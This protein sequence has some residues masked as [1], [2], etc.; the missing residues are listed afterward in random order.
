MLMKK[1]FTIAEI[2]MVIVI[3]GILAALTY[4]NFTIPKEKALDRE[5]K[6]TLALMRAAERI[7]RMEAG[8]AYY[9]YAGYTTTADVNLI[10]NNLKLSLPTT[11]PVANR[12]WAYSIDN[13]A[14][15]GINQAVRSGRTWTLDSAGPS[16]NPTCTG[17]CL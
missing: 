5:A 7:Y 11:L 1:G 9:P 3:V 13:N 12:N 6:A 8:G 10:N 2:L 16:E 17:A 4:P 15:T 14:S